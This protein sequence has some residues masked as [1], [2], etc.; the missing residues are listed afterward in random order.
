M[1]FFSL[2]TFLLFP[3]F[4]HGQS[5]PVPADTIRS[6]F[7]K[8]TYTFTLGVGF[9]N[10]YRQVYAVPMGYEKGNV[11]GF[12]PIY[13]RAE[14]AVSNHVSI[15]FGMA[16]NTIY[17]NSMRVDSGHTGIVR[18]S[19]ANKWRLFN[20]GIMALYHFGHILNT[21]KVDLYVGAGLNL[22]NIAQSGKPSGDSTIA[23]RSHSVTPAIR[24]GAR[25]FVSDVFSLH[26]DAGYDKLSKVCVG[27][28]CRFRDGK[29]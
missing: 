20:G 23:L 14:Y 2:L 4:V 7:A 17:F 28:S 27:V 1:R 25:Y 29:K 13:A 5:V 19:A 22:N 10:S 3:A 21:N 9:G 16:F 24:V 18:R 11:S 6:A 26:A 8:N 15:A 12:A